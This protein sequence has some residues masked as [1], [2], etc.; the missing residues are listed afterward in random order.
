MPDDTRQQPESTKK[1]TR[2]P[3]DT[4][5][6]M[7]E[8]HNLKILFPGVER[9]EL[10]ESFFRALGSPLWPAF[11]GTSGICNSVSHSP[12]PKGVNVLIDNTAVRSFIVCR[13]QRYS[14]PVTRP[15]QRRHSAVIAPVS[16]SQIPRCSDICQMHIPQFPFRFVFESN[17]SWPQWVTPML[18]HFLCE[19]WTR[20][21]WNPP[22]KGTRASVGL[23]I[24][25]Y[26]KLYWGTSNSS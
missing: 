24:I 20:T 13:N 8:D 1:Y 14:S 18:W 6:E 11:L 25:R 17:G 22:R 10:S 26:T 2:I 4:N 3:E 19:H 21:S 15:L 5:D 7:P 9:W 23:G 16:V 12:C